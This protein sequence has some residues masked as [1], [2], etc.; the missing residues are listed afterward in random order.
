MIP[1]LLVYLF[2][3]RWYYKALQ[4]TDRAQ[5][6]GPYIYIGSAILSVSAISQF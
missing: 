1:L 5:N 6:L 4:E 3:M 2:Y